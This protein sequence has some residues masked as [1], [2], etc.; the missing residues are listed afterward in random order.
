MAHE[1]MKFKDTYDYVVIN[2]KLENTVEEVSKI[3]LKECP[4]C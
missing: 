4:S 3:I 1:E 2:D